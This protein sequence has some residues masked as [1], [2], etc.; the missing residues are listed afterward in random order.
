M[1]SDGASRGIEKNRSLRSRTVKREV[2]EG[3]VERSV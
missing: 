3:I 2:P 1:F